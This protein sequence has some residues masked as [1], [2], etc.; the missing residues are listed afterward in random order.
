[1]TP[2]FFNQSAP[3][4]FRLGYC[5]GSLASAA[6]LALNDLAI[7]HIRAIAPRTPAEHSVTIPGQTPSVL[8]T[9]VT[10]VIEQEPQWAWKA[11]PVYAR[12]DERRSKRHASIDLTF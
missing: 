4:P 12:R 1:M 2:H 9:H 3:S 8:E 11:L 7:E 10:Q 5:A 6:V